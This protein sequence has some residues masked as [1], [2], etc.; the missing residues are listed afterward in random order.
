M[1]RSYRLLNVICKTNQKA[2]AD[3]IEEV[4]YT[5]Y[6]SKE[7]EVY[8]SM[9]GCYR[10]FSYLYGQILQ[11]KSLEESS[12][13][14]CPCC[15]HNKDKTASV[16]FDVCFGCT[17]KEA[18]AKFPVEPFHQEAYVLRDL[19][20]KEVMTDINAKIPE[21]LRKRRKKGGKDCPLRALTY[22]GKVSTKYFQG[23]R[24]TGLLGSICKHEFPLYFLNVMYGKE[25]QVFASR[26]WEHLHNL[27]P[28]RKWIAKYD[29]MCMFEK[30]LD[31]RGRPLPEITAIP[32]GHARFHRWSCQESWGPLS[33]KG[34]GL[35]VGEEIE[36]LWSY[37][38]LLWPRLKEMAP[39]NR[40]DELTDHLIYRGQQCL[41]NLHYKLETFAKRAAK[42][43]HEADTAI[44]ASACG[45]NVDNAEKWYQEFQ[46]SINPEDEES[47]SWQKTYAGL[48]HDLYAQRWVEHKQYRKGHTF[49][50][51]KTLIEHLA[52]IERQRRM[53][54]WAGNDPRYKEF[55]AKH[56][57][58]QM[59]YY[60]KKM[61]AA[62][63][64]QFFY[65]STS[66]QLMK[67]KHGHKGYKTRIETSNQISKASV[68]RQKALD[69]WN[70]YRA[71][72]YPFQQDLTVAEFIEYG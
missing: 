2:Y 10:A 59:E 12:R 52:L 26:V 60:R 67:H 11:G 8:R 35:S 23:L 33:V 15:M 55:T 57:R 27:D 54:R 68:E 17:G 1:L 3:Y 16:T 30:Y 38:M 47:L 7:I 13:I 51:R 69:Q 18:K 44:E 39:K 14:D 65:M 20:E 50:S 6:G 53:T 42:T 71:L 43:Y 45:L 22:S 21:H 28:K 31:A 61:V 48:L 19:T 70:Y 34:N 24:Y 32:S 40:I 9:Q 58:S 72:I 63:N 49:R 46:S 41:Q 56:W 66:R 25:K 36:L 62:D 4:S 5:K 64:D 37:L 29:I